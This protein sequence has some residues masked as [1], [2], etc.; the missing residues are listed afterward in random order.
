MPPRAT[1]RGAPL[2]RGSGPPTRGTRSGARGGPA[3][4]QIGLPSTNAHITTVGVKRPNFG[5]GG[6]EIP[7]SVNSFV[8][9]IPEGVIHHYDGALHILLA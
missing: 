2:S 1:A 5:T 4:I 9:T 8:T 6:R 3:S 7:I